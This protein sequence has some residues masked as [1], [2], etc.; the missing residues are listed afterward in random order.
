MKKSVAYTSALI[1]LTSSTFISAQTNR[2]PTIIRHIGLCDKFKI[3][4][5]DLTHE[6]DKIFFQGIYDDATEYVFATQS[7]SIMVSFSGSLRERQS[8]P[9]NMKQPITQVTI[10]RPGKTQ[11]LKVTG[12]CSSVFPLTAKTYPLKCSAKSPDGQIEAFFEVNV[13]N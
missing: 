1:L 9:P 11:V 6:C 12:Y 5:V 2:K 13:P 3:A 8:N 7:K 10:Q 4:Q